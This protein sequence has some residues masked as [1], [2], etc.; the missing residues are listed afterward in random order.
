MPVTIH[1]PLSILSDFEENLSLLEAMG[2]GVEPF[3]GN[4]FIIRSAPVFIDYAD[5]ASVVTGFIDS[6]EENPGVKTTN[7]ID[8]AL[9]QMAC[10]SS[11][12]S[13]DSVSRE[14]AAA[15]LDE[16]EKTENRQSCPHGR[17]VIFALPKK[18]IE[19]QFKR[20]GF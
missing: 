17:P 12:R 18:D 4:A 19:K 8:S 11:V 1:V 5:A 14:E 9:K 13:G 10:K 3:G 16:L 15:L 6:L 7:F 20:L 2:F